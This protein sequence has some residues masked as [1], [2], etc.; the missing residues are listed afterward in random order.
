MPARSTDVILRNRTLFPL[1][2]TDSGLDHGI[3]VGWVR[4]SFYYST[5]RNICVAVRE[6]GCCDWD[7]GSCQL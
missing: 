1:A 5:R 4:P 3:W 6:R 2:L 7:R